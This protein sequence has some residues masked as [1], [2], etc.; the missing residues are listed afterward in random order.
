ML[1]YTF[2]LLT[3]FYFFRT[4]LRYQL[5]NHWLKKQPNSRSS[6]PYNFLCQVV[7]LTGLQVVPLIS[8]FWKLFY[9]FNRKRMGPRRTCEAAATQT[10]KISTIGNRGTSSVVT[11]YTTASSKNDA[12]CSGDADVLLACCHPAAS[13][14]NSPSYPT[15]SESTPFCI[16]FYWETWAFREFLRCGWNIWVHFFGCFWWLGVGG[17]RVSVSGDWRQF[18]QLGPG[19]QRHCDETA[20]RSTKAAGESQGPHCQASSQSHTDSGRFP[21]T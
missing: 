18:H 20:R 3:I 17:Y 16:F 14:S 21:V 13:A 11:W 5:Q 19:Y 7:Q 10:K 9:S 12:P 4:R 2:L 6:L 15:N 1:L 8:L